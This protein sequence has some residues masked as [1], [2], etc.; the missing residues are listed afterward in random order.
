MDPDSLQP[1]GISELHTF[2][3]FGLSRNCKDAA[4][5]LRPDHV[6]RVISEHET[7]RFD[8]GDTIRR[9]TL[10]R[11]HRFY[12]CLCLGLEIEIGEMVFNYK[13]PYLAFGKCLGSLSILFSWSNLL[14]MLLRKERKAMAFSSR[15]EA[16]EP[17]DTDDDLAPDPRPVGN[18]ATPTKPSPRENQTSAN[19]PK[20]N[21]RLT[22][23]FYEADLEEYT[24]SKRPRLVDRPSI[25]TRRPENAG[26]KKVHP[27][28]IRLRQAHPGNQQKS[29][30]T[31][32][33]KGDS[34]SRHYNRSNPQNSIEAG[35]EQMKIT[36]S[37][38]SANG[39][40]YTY[41]SQD[42]IE[43][44]MEQM[45]IAS[46]L[47]SED[48]DEYTYNSQDSSEAETDRM[49]TTPSLGSEDEDMFGDD[50]LS[51]Q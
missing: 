45:E 50:E 14:T 12:A 5:V 42:S 33:V 26:I 16:L 48:E 25:A 15:S 19:A 2:H 11:G 43:A 51:S 27:L 38:A 46:S 39:R 23:K 31:M 17:S 22:R 30:M 21:Q 7:S 6:P 3:F 29:S 37:L 47:T 36:S 32:Q 34:R 8:H 41:S 9:L 10:D 4:F 44:R 1:G 18:P 49:E 24:P 28:P 20:K 13:P 35:M 40:M